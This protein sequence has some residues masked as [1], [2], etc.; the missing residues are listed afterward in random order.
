MVLFLRRGDMVGFAAHHARHPTPVIGKKTQAQ[1]RKHF[2]RHA[3]EPFQ[4]QVAVLRDLPDDKTDLIHMRIDHDRRQ[5]RPFSR[6]PRNHIPGAIK[7]NGVCIR[8]KSLSHPLRHGIFIARRG[9]QQHQL[10]QTV[11]DLHFRL[12]FSLFRMYHDDRFHK[13]LRLCFDQM[14]RLFVILKFKQMRHQ[15]VNPELPA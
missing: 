7:K 9:R 8:R 12:R 13:A 1:R 6:E 2:F 10:S 14:D 5:I 15:M 4:P 3:A 11:H